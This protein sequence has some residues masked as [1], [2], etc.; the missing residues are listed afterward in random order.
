M[1]KQF[2]LLIGIL[3]LLVNQSYGQ[4]PLNF[5]HPQTGNTITS[6]NS[7]DAAGYG[8]ENDLEGIVQNLFCY[9]E[10]A[11][12]A[13]SVD[14]VYERF[15]WYLMGKVD[16]DQVL[17]EG[18]TEASITYDFT[19]SGYH[20]FRVY[21][22]NG[23]GDD[24]CYEITDIAVYVAP[25]IILEVDEEDDDFCENDSEQISNYNEKELTVSASYEETHMQDD[26]N[27]VYKFYLTTNEGEA[28]LLQEGSTNTYVLGSSD[29]D[30]DFTERLLEQGDYK[31][32]V[33]VS[34]DFEDEEALC[35]KEETLLTLVIN[36]IPEKPVIE[37]TGGLGRN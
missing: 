15:E 7:F 9:E 10:G 3:I 22:F 14:G 37:I 6:F 33:R 31:Y 24:A 17:L 30:L 13:L 1:K 8:A 29:N 28:I 27:L 25:E 34:Y 12:V 4:Y 26:F 32:T 11:K 20:R 18:E 23:S 19:R 2:Y 16:E 35:E 36:P 21:G 5:T